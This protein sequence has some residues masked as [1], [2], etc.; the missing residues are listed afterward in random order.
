MKPSVG[1][2]LPCQLWVAELGKPQTVW[3][4]HPDHNRLDVMKTPIGLAYHLDWSLSE[5]EIALYES[6]RTSGP[7]VPARSSTA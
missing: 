1:V 2:E 5:T 6:E 7:F 3:L 4:Y